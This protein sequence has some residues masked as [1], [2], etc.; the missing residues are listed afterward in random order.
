MQHKA[1]VKRKGQRAELNR[2]IAAIL[3][4][5]FTIVTLAGCSFSKGR[6]ETVSED[7]VSEDVM[8][9]EESLQG[10]V[11][12]VII[13][14]DADTGNIKFSHIDTGKK[15]ELKLTDETVYFGKTGNA[16][17]KEQIGVGDMADIT[18]SLHS[19]NVKTVQLVDGFTYSGVTDYNFSINKGIFTT[20][21]VN[22]RIGDNTVVIKNSELASLEDIMQGD[23]LK[24][25]GIDHDLYAITVESGIGYVRLTGGEY[26]KGGIVD[27]GKKISPIEDDMLMEIPEGQYEMRVIYNNSTAKRAISVA[28]SKETFVNLAELKG[29]LI[30]YGKVSFTFDPPDAHVTVKID[31]KEVSSMRPVELEYGIHN[32]IISA[33]GYRTIKNKIR[34]AQEMANLDVVLEAA[35]SENKA[36]ENTEKKPPVSGNPATIPSDTFKKKDNNTASSNTSNSTETETTTA[37]SDKTTK[38][39]E[40]K[41]TTDNTQDTSTFTTTAG[42][43]S[44]QLIIDSPEGAEV[45]FDGAYKGIIPISFTKTA[46][47]HVVVLRKD[48]YKAKTYTL[49]LTGVENETYSFNALQQIED[50]EDE[51]D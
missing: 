5:L 33:Q 15:Y 23:T 46:G 35:A 4:V 20:A 12:T 29:D 10:T 22:Y 11:R 6:K 30:K 21:D 38:T 45:Y 17:V 43:T 34:V 31:G 2:R 8:P 14:I 28:R 27:I 49:N 32:L 48:G 24:I 19:G 26:F 44:N 3:V 47:T 42:S 51:E 39:T 41:E 36:E 7:T 16:M 25:S 40:T 18:A 9:T 1:G 37:A 13:G 50:D